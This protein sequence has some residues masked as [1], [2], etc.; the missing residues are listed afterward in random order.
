MLLED[1]PKVELSVELNIARYSVELLPR[2]ELELGA[3]TGEL[4]PNT[5][6][7]LSG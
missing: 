2:A 7:E 3:S 4:S 1:E 6:L 5:E